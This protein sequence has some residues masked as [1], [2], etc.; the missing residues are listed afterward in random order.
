MQNVQHQPQVII[1]AACNLHATQF[2]Q[3]LFCPLRCF[4]LLR[5]NSCMFLTDIP[6][7]WLECL[8]PPPTLLTPHAW[9]IL[10]KPERAPCALTAFSCLSFI[11]EKKE[12]AFV[13]CSESPAHAYFAQVSSCC[14]TQTR[15]ANFLTLQ[16]ALACAF[17][18]LKQTKTHLCVE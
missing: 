9:P 12:R 11:M 7:S 8:E 15:R 6:F 10:T 4:C 14:W 5:L 17:V 18:L 1:Y 2:L 13:K 3:L 16:K